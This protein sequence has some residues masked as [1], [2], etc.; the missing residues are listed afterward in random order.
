LHWR[1]RRANRELARERVPVEHT[2]ASVKRLG[3]LRQVLRA[4]RKTT[5][6]DVMLIGCALHNYRLA[7][8][9]AAQN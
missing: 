4:R 3:I 7:Q 6:D 8:K 2:L 1:H 9:A 5:A